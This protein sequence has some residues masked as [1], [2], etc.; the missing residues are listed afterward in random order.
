MSSRFRE[1][2][3]ARLAALLLAGASAIA[4]AGLPSALGSGALRVCADP[5]NAPF[6]RRDGSG[7]ENRIAAL[8]ADALGAQLRY[9]WWPQGRGFLRNTL[10][11][12]ACDVVI[13]V[14]ARSDAVLTTAPYYR[15]GYV[16]AYRADRLPGLSSYDDPRLA[17]LR[18]GVPLVGN[19]MAAT[20]PGNALARRGIADNVIGYVPLGTAPVAQRMMDAL[21]DGTLDVALLWAPQAGYFAH[22]QPFE[23]RLVS[24]IDP[25]GN[26]PQLFDIAMG[27]RRNDV[28]LR[29][30]LSR[31]LD[32]IRPQIDAV[33]R[34][35]EV[36]VESRDL[37]SDARRTP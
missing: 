36:P 7:F 23:V 30:T 4:L 37:L 27:V 5:D 8:M 15:A 6:S 26:E 12:G 13:G 29:D 28:A 22:R 31:T 14:P 24:A 35:Y 21:A 2:D 3:F 32:R 19:D 33:L 20:P 34:E 17:R 16:F 10:A 1:R 9:Y 11:A 25:R 18:I